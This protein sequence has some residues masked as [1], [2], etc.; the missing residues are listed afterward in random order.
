MQFQNSFIASLHTRVLMWNF[1]VPFPSPF[2]WNESPSQLHTTFQDFQAFLLWDN[3]KT[4]YIKLCF[5][6]RYKVAFQKSYV[7]I[8]QFSNRKV[9][10]TFFAHLLVTITKLQCMWDFVRLTTCI[11][12]T[13]EWIRTKQQWSKQHTSKLRQHK[14]NGF[15][16]WWWPFKEL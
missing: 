1:R 8:N 11:L 12:V 7:K 2:L 16:W 6:T 9:A 13:G 15:R 10:V 5:T 4:N 14:K 3:N